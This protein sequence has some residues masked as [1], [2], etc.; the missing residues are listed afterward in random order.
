MCFRWQSPSQPP[1][2][3]YSPLLLLRMLRIHLSILPREPEENLALILPDINMRSIKEP[4]RITHIGM[5]YAL[6]CRAHYIKHYRIVF[7]LKQTR[8]LA[9]AAY[10]ISAMEDR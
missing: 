3:P 8:F 6:A 5:G 10:I 4:K 2:T 7:L 1:I 9:M